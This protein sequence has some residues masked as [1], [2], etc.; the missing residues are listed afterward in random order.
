MNIIE[1][2]ILK[3]FE[4]LC[5]R[6][7]NR[8]VESSGN[9]KDENY[10]KEEYKKASFEIETMDI[11]CKSWKLHMEHLQLYTKRLLGKTKIYSPFV[12]L[13][14]HWYQFEI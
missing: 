7:D 4:F 10:S 2:N 13:L 12:I 9:K 11:P 1:K 3:H 8:R 6:I 5:E 14:H